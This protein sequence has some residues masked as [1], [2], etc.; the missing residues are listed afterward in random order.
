MA[1]VFKSRKDQDIKIGETNDI[2]PGEYLPQTD[3]K[4]IKVSKEPF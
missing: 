4:I 2:G 3:L 1:F